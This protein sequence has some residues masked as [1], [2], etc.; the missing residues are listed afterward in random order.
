MSTVKEPLH[1]LKTARYLWLGILLCALVGGACFLGGRWSAGQSENVQ[2][3]AVVLQN[4]LTEIR[5]LATVTYAYTNMAQFES[6]NDF[7]GMK[8]PF[9]TKSFI[10]T[11]DGTIKAGVDLDGA[12]VNV[13][14]TAVTITL[15][16]ARIL[17][18]GI[19]EDS[20]EVFDEKTSIFNPF[21]VE[22]FTSFQADQ[23]AAM[24][25]RALSRGLLEEARRKAVSS[26]EQLLSAA[27]PDPYTVE[28]Q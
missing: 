24:E 1:P 27:L 3:D 9:T 4:Q 23:K 26:V 20:V 8:V 10:L 6:S 28:I 2:I 7:Y 16:E 13:S 25:E 17:S 15:P 22:D 18:H 11:Y 21:T 19:D 12:E 5:E 14:G